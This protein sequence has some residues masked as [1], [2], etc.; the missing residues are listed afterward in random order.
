MKSLKRI[1]LIM[2]AV[3][4]VLGGAVS[5]L[6]NGNT[7]VE[8]GDPA[9]VYTG[10]WAQAEQEPATQGLIHYT[11]TGGD[12]AEFTFSGTY[13]KLISKKGPGAGIYDIYLDNVKVQS[14]D[15]YADTATFMVVAYENNELIPGEHT[16]KVVHTGEKNEA[17][18]GFAAHI[19]AIEFGGEVAPKPDPETQA[20]ET[21]ETGN[22]D[23]DN[24]IA[25]RQ[26]VES[27]TTE[28]PKTGDAGV[29]AFAFIA[30]SGLATMIKLR[31]KF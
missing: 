1:S 2:L 15:G 16:I 10:E 22:K 6:G 5:V 9:I 18:G 3:V 26:S 25:E 12:S 28:N 11:V 13:V 31:K 7:I 4:I 19:D 27:Q 17:A 20:A 14:F 21:Q 23:A 29:M 24:Q 30:C 8:N